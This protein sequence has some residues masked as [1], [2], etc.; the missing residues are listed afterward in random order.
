MSRLLTP[1]TISNPPTITAQPKDASACPGGQAVLRVKADGAGLKYQ[2]RRAGTNIA[3]A[4]ADSLVVT[5]DATTIGKY[6]CVVTGTCNPSVTS[7]GVNLVTA[8]ATA[9]TKQPTGL[10]VQSGSPITLSVAATGSTLSYQWSRNGTP[11]PGATS[12]E[13]TVTS[14]TSADAG[15]Y[16]CAVTGGCGTVTSE[17][18]AVVVEGTSVD[19]E[20]HVNSS[21]RLVGR[22]PVVDE[23]TV[24]IDLPV[25]SDVT[26]T[27]M[28]LRGRTLETLTVGGLSSGTH[29]VMISTKTCQSG[30]HSLKVSTAAGSWTLLVMVVR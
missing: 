11:I 2:W 30:L 23:T 29:D 6:D 22:Y 27:L 20:Y 26:V 25:A 8:I 12:A 4:T 21:I 3:G 5:V 1:F 14:A 24:R 19:E 10:T 7:A 13:Y 15:D 28:D 18:A 9:I 17:K 16:T